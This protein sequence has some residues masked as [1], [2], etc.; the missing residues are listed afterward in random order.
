MTL[1]L[2]F[3]NCRNCGIVQKRCKKTLKETASDI[4]INTSAFNMQFNTIWRSIK[5]YF[6]K[7]VL[8]GLRLLISAKCMKFVSVF[9]VLV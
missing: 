3:Q 9:K 2:D 7:I 8:N 4:L 1:W 5:M 6:K